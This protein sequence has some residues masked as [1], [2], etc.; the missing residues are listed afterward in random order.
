MSRLWKSTINFAVA[1]EL[2]FHWL[3]TIDGTPATKNASSSENKKDTTF[4]SIDT[5]KLAAGAVYYQ[6]PMHLEVMS[7]K[8][9]TCPKCDMELE[10][11]T[12]RA[13]D[14]V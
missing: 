2:T 11:R 5:T 7:D 8:A 4:Q 12:N 9:G 6:C 10:K 3:A 13:A 14:P 1:A